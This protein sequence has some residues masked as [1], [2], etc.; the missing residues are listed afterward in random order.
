M[1]TPRVGAF[2]RPESGLKFAPGIRHRAP[3]KSG[4]QGLRF[5]RSQAPLF[6]PAPGLILHGLLRQPH[7]GGE[8]T[9][10]KPMFPHPTPQLLLRPSGQGPRWSVDDMF[11]GT[12]RDGVLVPFPR[13]QQLP[14]GGCPPQHINITD[15]P[16]QSLIS[17]E[18]LRNLVFLLRTLRCRLLQTL[19]GARRNT[20]E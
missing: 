15:P 1:P 12:S 9:A 19:Q 4:T 11:R 6:R 16:Q 20:G 3:A 14:A 18:G 5:P 13:S 17:N 8:S 10:H 2:W 7:A